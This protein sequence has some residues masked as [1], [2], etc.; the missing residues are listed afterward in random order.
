MNHPFCCM[1]LLAIELSL[2]QRT[3]YNAL[4]VGRKTPKIVPSP[5]DFVTLP[6]EDRATAIGKTCTKFGKDRA[7]MVPEICL[8]TDRPQTHR[9]TDVLI[10]ILRRRSDGATRRCLRLGIDRSYYAAV[11]PTRRRTRHYS[12][13]LTTR[14]PNCQGLK[15]YR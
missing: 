1:T 11:P 8:R 13:S 3:H 4:S 7:C 15:Y 6:E 12:E 5:W 2:L 10:T 9:H 14:H